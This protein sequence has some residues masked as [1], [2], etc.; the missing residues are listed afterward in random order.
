M[1]DLSVLVGSKL[2]DG[3][4]SAPVDG[5]YSPR[6]A[7]QRLLDGTGL[8]ASFVSENSVV[9]MPAPASAQA[10]PEPEPVPPD[11][12]SAPPVAGAMAGGND[13]LSYAAMIQARLAEALCQSAQTR[14]G[15]YRLLV[16]FH[17][18][19]SGAIVSPQLL[20]STG[21]P[22]RDAAISQ[23]IGG[24]V[25]DSAPPAALQQP[26]TILF[27]PQDRNTDCPAAEAQDE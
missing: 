1:T 24:V 23:S 11:P 6:D 5:D 3:R 19:A 4:V 12:D 22:A 21:L 25:L 8:Q 18:D 17:I 2:L 14:P 15:T 13:Y 7:L 26:V 10:S 9:L 27:R 16:Q 20:E